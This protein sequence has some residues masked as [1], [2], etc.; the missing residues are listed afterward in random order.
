[1][2]N[3]RFRQSRKKT[4]ARRNLH[5]HALRVSR[6][7]Q[8]ADRD[9][10]GAIYSAWFKAIAEKIANLTVN[11]A[12]TREAKAAFDRIDENRDNS[13]TQDEFRTHPEKS[14][15]PYDGPPKKYLW[16]QRPSGR[17][18]CRPLRMLTKTTVVA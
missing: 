4:V 14:I 3:A 17:C 7:F 6:L 1:M 8:A 13:L 5:G 16:T 11:T 12:M 2:T 15:Q 18:S 10:S 9:K